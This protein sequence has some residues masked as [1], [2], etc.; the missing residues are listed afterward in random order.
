MQ[1]KSIMYYCLLGHFKGLVQS[2][3]M[4]YALAKVLGIA[5]YLKP[6][7]DFAG[8]ELIFRNACKPKWYFTI[9]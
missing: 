4:F 9:S 8:T 3:R 1:H 5:I 2:Y 6:Q 7:F